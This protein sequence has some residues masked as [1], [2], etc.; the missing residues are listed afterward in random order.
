[1][2]YIVCFRKKNNLHKNLLRF[3]NLR[4]DIFSFL[5]LV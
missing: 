2:E 5:T 1:M 4:A 3:F